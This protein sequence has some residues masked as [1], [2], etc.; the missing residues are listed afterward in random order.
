[1]KYR[2]LGASLVA[3]GVL[4]LGISAAASHATTAMTVAT[5]GGTGTTPA[6]TKPLFWSEEFSKIVF[7]NT[8]WV[9]NHTSAYQYGNTNPNDSKLDL[10]WQNSAAVNVNN[11]IVKFTAAP[12]STILPNGKRAWTTGLLG[13]EPSTE[14]FQV[15]ANDYIETRV[16]LP[17]QAGAWPA[18]WTWKNGGN[19][20]DTFEYHPDNP[21]LLELSNHV[22]NTGDYYT[23]ASAVYP[24]AWV[25]IGTYYGTSSV[26]WYVNG[27]KVFSDNKGVPASW[28]AYL[29]LNLSISS[30]TYHPAPVGTTPITFQAD[31][32]RVY[33]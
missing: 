9:G 20:V 3:A 28:S 32:V 15:Q 6:S 14:A 7:W 30:G 16:Q 26:D 4:G 13:T 22:A 11:G 24:G 27:V 17:S 10:L 29:I 19:E 1:M 21:N 18:L 33:R 23:N 2:A 12:S 25:T 31:Y 5:C 8:K